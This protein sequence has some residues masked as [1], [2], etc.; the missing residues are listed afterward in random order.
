MI[1]D[2]AVTYTQLTSRIGFWR[3]RLS[4]KFEP[5]CIVQPVL[6]WASTGSNFERFLAKIPIFEVN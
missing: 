4:P 5:G 6:P 1:L 3:R 2:L